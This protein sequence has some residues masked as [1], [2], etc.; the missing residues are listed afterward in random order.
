MFSASLVSMNLHFALDISPPR[1]RG[2]R[3]AGYQPWG[4]MCQHTSQQEEGEGPSG[5]CE[6]SS[7]NLW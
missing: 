2:L 6:E 3:P 7:Y 5:P 4:G 1:A